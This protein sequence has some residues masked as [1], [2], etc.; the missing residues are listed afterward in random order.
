MSGSQ[1]QCRRY[2]DGV[3]ISCLCPMPGAVPLAF[4]AD[5]YKRRACRRGR[6]VHHVAM[7]ISHQAI[8][9]AM[10]AAGA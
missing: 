2:A 10:N 1:Y 3:A 9:A 6:Q 8:G 7:E 4:R 5:V